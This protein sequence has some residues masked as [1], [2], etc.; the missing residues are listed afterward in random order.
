M[1]TQHSA[2]MAGGCISD[3]GV[4][5]AVSPLWQWLTPSVW[6]EEPP[7]LVSLVLTPALT[8]V[9]HHDFC[10]CRQKIGVFV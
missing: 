4:V 8:S 2:L 5:G 1:Y 3:L 10:D 7:L 6:V 9:R